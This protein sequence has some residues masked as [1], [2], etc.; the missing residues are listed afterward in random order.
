MARLPVVS[1]EDAIRAFERDG[2]RLIRQSGSHIIMT[3]PGI[4]VVLS[5]PDHRE[6]K[7]GTLR[8]LIRKAGLDVGDFLALIRA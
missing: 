2:W 8:E 7:R 5:I 6:L 3:K 1:G 4:G